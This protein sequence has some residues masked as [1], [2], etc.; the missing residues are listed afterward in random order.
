MFAVQSV[1]D[2]VSVKDTVIW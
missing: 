1:G 2:V